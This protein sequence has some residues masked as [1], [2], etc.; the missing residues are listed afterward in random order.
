LTVVWIVLG[1]VA[2]AAL[3]WFFQQ[4]KNAVWG[5]LMMG[6]VGG[7]IAA[8]CYRDASGFPWSVVGKWIVVCV[9]LGVA[10]ELLALAGKRKEDK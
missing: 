4:G 8:F 9:L 10:A 3:A 1:I 7:L 6:I 2:V 5:G